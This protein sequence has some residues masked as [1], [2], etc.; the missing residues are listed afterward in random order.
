MGR[1]ADDMI[2][3]ACNGAH[4]PA[5]HIARETPK[6]CSRKRRA[7]GLHLARLS[8]DTRKSVTLSF[9][10]SENI[11]CGKGGA[12]QVKYQEASAAA[13]RVRFFIQSKRFTFTTA[14]KHFRI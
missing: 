2:G 9:N 5:L 4:R 11:I 3:L 13:P 10:V 6:P 8:Q 14:T 7:A 12:C 1:S